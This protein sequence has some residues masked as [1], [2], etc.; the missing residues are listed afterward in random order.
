MYLLVQNCV[1]IVVHCITS[2]DFMGQLF[3]IVGNRKINNTKVVKKKA[4]VFKKLNKASM[5]PTPRWS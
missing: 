1:H 5:K 3:G 2:R 4:F